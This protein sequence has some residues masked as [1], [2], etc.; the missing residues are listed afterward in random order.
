MA[1]SSRC[2]CSQGTVTALP[3]FRSSILRATSSSQA[4]W[5]DSLLLSR[6]SSRVLANAARSSGERASARFRRSEISGLIAL[7]YPLLQACHK[8]PRFGPR[9]L[10]SRFSD[11]PACPEVY[12]EG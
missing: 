12:A 1:R 3:F 2:S 11:D 8:Y 9:G 7:F 10:A 5:T 4:S 6:L